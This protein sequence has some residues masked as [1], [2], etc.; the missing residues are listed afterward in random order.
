MRAHGDVV[1]SS[2]SISEV[3]QRRAQ[4]VLEWMIGA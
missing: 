2:R 1:T 4:L 3:K